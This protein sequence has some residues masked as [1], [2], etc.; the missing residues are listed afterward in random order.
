[1]SDTIVPQQDAIDVYPSEDVGV[2]IYQQRSELAV[3]GCPD[4]EAYIHVRPENAEQLCAAIMAC[5][6]ELDADAA[7]SPARQSKDTTAAERQKRYR[8][9]QRELRGEDT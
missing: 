4:A 6:A 2:I 7:H 1:M 3:L 9:R 8:Q 5:A